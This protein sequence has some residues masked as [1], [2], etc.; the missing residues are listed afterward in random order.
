MKKGIV[1]TLIVSL[2]A[3]SSINAL[4]F[5]DTSIANTRDLRIQERINRLEQSERLEKGERQEIW[6]TNLTE[7]ITTYAPE[8]LADYT[9]SWADHDAI[10]ADLQNI[11]TTAQA[12]NQLELDA[13]KAKVTAKEITLAQ[14][15]ELLKA[16]YESNKSNR[17][18]IFAEI[19]T[20]KAVYGQDP[21]VVKATLDTLKSAIDNQETDTIV[22]SLYTLLEMLEKHIQFDQMK[23]DLVNQI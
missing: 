22:N 14:A 1:L 11:R 13:I 3:F 8:L 17:E 20:L 4:T 12:N 2:I 5:A 15:R 6:R 19:E 16:H 23:L 9:A 7:V 10:H 21:E 18:A